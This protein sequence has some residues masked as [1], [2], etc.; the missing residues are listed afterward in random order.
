MIG[1]LR[2]NGQDRVSRGS[3]LSNYRTLPVARVAQNTLKCHDLVGFM[4]LFRR[5]TRATK[6]AD[7]TAPPPISPAPPLSVDRP[8][9]PATQP[10][11]SISLSD[12]QKSLLEKPVDPRVDRILQEIYEDKAAAQRALNSRRIIDFPFGDTGERHVSQDEQGFWRIVPGPVP[13]KA[14]RLGDHI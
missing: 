7:A 8:R 2:A 6:S 11:L 13:M 1:P 12:E 9:A 5:H 4:K 14:M 3:V 10:S